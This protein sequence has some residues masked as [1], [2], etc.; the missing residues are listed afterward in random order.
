MNETAIIKTGNG[1]H[2]IHT[3]K[4]IDD[5]HSQLD[6]FA[7]DYKK[8]WF[9]YV[10]KIADSLCGEFAFDELREQCVLQPAHPNW[11]GAV[12][13]KLKAAGYIITGMGKSNRKSRRG[14]YA[15]MWRK[16]VDIKSEREK[17]FKNM[18]LSR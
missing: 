14:G 11:W 9:S 2:I 7:G 16:G 3:R 4:I 5:S 8:Q 13:G 1:K 15:C 12:S 6:L 18:Q 17:S 10:L